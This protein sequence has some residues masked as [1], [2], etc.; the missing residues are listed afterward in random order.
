[1]PGPGL[2]YAVNFVPKPGPMGVNKLGPVG[3]GLKCR[4]LPQSPES[5]LNPIGN[6]WDVLE[7]TLHSGP[8]L[9]S[10]IQDLGEKLMQ[11][12]MGINVMT[13]LKLTEM[14]P[15]RMGAV[16]KAKSGPMKY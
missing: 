4:S 16:I 15:R 13:L 5:D 3:L 10:S 14:M 1:M 2:R 9:P 11:L 6:L 7:K 12:W 8:T